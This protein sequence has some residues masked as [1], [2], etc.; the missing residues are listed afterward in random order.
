MGNEEDD[1][2]S[3]SNSPVSYS[4]SISLMGSSIVLMLSIIYY[5]EFGEVE[6]FVCLSL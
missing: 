6:G 4:V 1:W 2:A 5:G 3:V